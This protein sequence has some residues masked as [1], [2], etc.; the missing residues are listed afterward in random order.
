LHSRSSCCCFSRAMVSSSACKIQVLTDHDCTL[1]RREMRDN[2]AWQ[3]QILLLVEGVLCCKL[4][5]ASSVNVE[6][7][8][9]TADT[10]E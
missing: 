1:S 2:A 5:T 8:C 3:T 6:P 9:G 10:Q 7:F 4:S